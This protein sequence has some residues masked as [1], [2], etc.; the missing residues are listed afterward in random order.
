MPS[1]LDIAGLQCTR[2][3]LAS[4]C[5]VRS[6]IRR[7]LLEA[8]VSKVRVLH[9]YRCRFEVNRSS[10]S[11]HSSGYCT[12]CSCDPWAVPAH[13]ASVQPATAAG[14]PWPA[15]PGQ[16]QRQGRFSSRDR[17]EQLAARQPI[18]TPSSQHD[19]AGLLYA[20]GCAG[21]PQLLRVE[22]V[23]ERVRHPAADG[24]HGLHHLV[25]HR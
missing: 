5:M 25:V 4:N 15:Q 10:R 7:R 11:F 16:H 24:D 21:G 13:A 8:V 1:E 14:H 12:L 3:T 2:C 19:Q 23:Y 20:T 6:R 9:M 18:P 22:K 17:G